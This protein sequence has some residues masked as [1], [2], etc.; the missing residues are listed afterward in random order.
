M[1]FT[2][3]STLG[4]SIR[5]SII[6]TST[7]TLELFSGTSTG[8]QV[9]SASSAINDSNWHMVE[10]KT[11]TTA[12][13]GSRV[14][15]ARLDGSVFATSSAQSQS[16]TLAFS[17]GGNLGAEAQTTGEWWFDDVALNDTTGSFQTSYP[18]SGKILQLYPNATGDSNTFSTQT[19]GTAGAANNFTRVNE[20]PPDDAT[21]FNGDN[22]L[23][24]VDLFNVTDSGIGSSDTVNV[25]MVGARFANNVADA[26]TAIK[27]EIEK[28]TSGTKS[29]SAAIIPNTIGWNTNSTTSP[30]NYP[31]ITY[32]DPDSSNWT[33]ST[34][35]SAQIGYIISAGSTNRVDV[36]NVW[37]SV[38]YTPVAPPVTN[39]SLMM[40]GMGS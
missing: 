38:D 39:P 14:L 28:T 31:L 22:T 4:G 40:M 10:L 21:S 29:Q 15:E 17:L 35:D 8:T 30:R 34:L 6:L 19:G 2:A 23:N 24:D 1:S 11:D 18:G 36:T 5:C 32:Q 7:G 16:T 9:G 33:K 26:T 20:V 12:A 13:V 25:V 27:F 37:M 3:S